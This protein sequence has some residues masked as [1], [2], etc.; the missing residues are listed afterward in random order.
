MIDALALLV[1]FLAVLAAFTQHIAWAV[2]AAVA[3]V[4]IWRTSHNRRQEL[5]RARRAME[6]AKQASNTFRPTTT[7]FPEDS[8][9]WSADSGSGRDS[10]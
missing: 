6:R 8:Q 2:V 9:A 5:R 3:A 7:A 10:K 4:L 1:M